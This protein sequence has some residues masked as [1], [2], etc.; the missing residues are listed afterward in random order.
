[1]KRCTCRHGAERGRG[2]MQSNRCIGA[3]ASTSASASAS[4]MVQV[5]KWSR[6]ACAEVQQVHVQSAGADIEGP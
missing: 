6:G 2:Q 1:M 4:A 5:Q 3:G